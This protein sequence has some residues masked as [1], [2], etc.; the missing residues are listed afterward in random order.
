M[1]QQLTSDIQNGNIRSIARVISLVENEV[2][3]YS[4]FMKDLPASSTPVI[5]VTGPPGAGKSTLTDGLIEKLVAQ[6][7]SIG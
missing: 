2:S 4:Q 5:G 6:N 7:T 3:G 1:W